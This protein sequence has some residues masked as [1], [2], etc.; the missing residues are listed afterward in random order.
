MLSVGQDTRTKTERVK[1]QNTPIDAIVPRFQV[2]SFFKQKGASARGVAAEGHFRTCR[3][4]LLKASSPAPDM[5]ARKAECQERKTNGTN[6][7]IAIQNCQVVTS[8]RIVISF[9]TLSKLILYCPLRMI[10]KTNMR[11]TR[12]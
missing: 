7:T 1:K 3:I 2:C 8:V 9:G 4:F 6:L 5:Y 12:F 10:Y 11:I